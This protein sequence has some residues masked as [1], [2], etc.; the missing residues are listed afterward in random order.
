MIK[1][2]IYSL[3]ATVLD[4]PDVEVGGVL[5][6]HNGMIHGG[7]SYVYYTGPYDAADG[8][9]TGKM[10]SREHAPTTRPIA[11]LVQKIEFRGNYN[12]DGAKA[13]ATAVVGKQRVRHDATLRFLAEH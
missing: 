3:S 9:W 10:V 12:E 2:G 11:E 7:D 1:N 13:S 4:G 8:K 5:I 6:L